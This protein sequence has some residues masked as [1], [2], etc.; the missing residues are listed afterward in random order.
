[1]TSDPGEPQSETRQPDPDRVVVRYVGVEDVGPIAE[2]ML[3]CFEQ[4]PWF[5]IDCSVA[6]HLHWKLSANEDSWAQQIVASLDDDDSYIVALAIRI[7]RPGWLRG[8]Q[9]VVA[10]V[11]DQSVHPDWRR[12]H[13]NQK[14]SDLRAR[15]GH[16]THDFQMSWLPNHPATRKEGLQRTELG[17]A[18]L[19]FWKPASLRSLFSVP[20][21]TAGAKHAARVVFQDL[22]RRARRVLERARPIRGKRFDGKV[23]DLERFDDRTDAVWEAAKPAFDFAIAR[24]QEY[25]NWRYADPRS[26]RFLIRGVLEGDE[27]LGYSVTRP[28]SDPVEIVDLLVH[29]GRFD[30]LDALIGDVITTRERTA[31]GGGARD[32]HCWLPQRHPYRETLLAH[33]FLDSGR[34]PSFRFRPATMSA[35]ELAFLT[36]PATPVHITLGDSDFA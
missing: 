31:S 28:Y 7:R 4:W 33:G 24:T 34:D 20:L 23:V 19:V 32:I 30:A 15:D 16:D 18:V 25:L 9:C 35:E 3:R 14:R 29:P 13:I 36:D 11:V 1:M 21:R 17:N 10:D 5:E 8:R 2:H 6:E 22:R 27:L 12:M 26:G